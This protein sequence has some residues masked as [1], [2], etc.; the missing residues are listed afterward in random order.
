MFKDRTEAGKLLVSAISK[1]NLSNA[2]VLAIPRGGVVV[3]AEISKAYKLPLRLI[4]VKKVGHPN[5]PEFS[6]GAI[7][8]DEN[9]IELDSDF[10]QNEIVDQL[11]N[12]RSKMQKQFRT[13][14]HVYSDRN[15]KDKVVLLVDDGAATGNSILFSIK[16]LKKIPVKTIVV[17]LPVCPADTFNKIAQIADDLVCLEVPVNFNAVGQFYE[18]FQQVADD[19]VLKI[20]KTYSDRN[21]KG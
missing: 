10:T 13:Y 14:G 15:L 12:A 17:L 18:D 19:E 8:Q 20:V 5:N 16:E 2:I 9:Q 3:A 11:R 7:G 1:Y 4:F 21:K 6:I